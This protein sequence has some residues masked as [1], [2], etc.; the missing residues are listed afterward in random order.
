MATLFYIVGATF[1]IS[2]ISLFGVILVSH[3]G[4]F[5]KKTVFL[6][7]G[8]STGTLLGGAFLHLIPE[9]LEFLDIEIVSLVI[10]ISFVAFFLIERLFHWHHC[11]DGECD[12]HQFGYVNL[13]GD[14]IHNFI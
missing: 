11:H 4:E 13:L 10:L 7:V 1:V 14:A 9:S 3:N 2:L 12:V 5:L 8:L 6:L